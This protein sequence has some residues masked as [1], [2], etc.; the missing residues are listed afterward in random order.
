MSRPPRTAPDRAIAGAG[1]DPIDSLPSLSAPRR[2]DA[3]LSR[4]GDRVGPVLS[5]RAASPV[6]W[7]RDADRG[8]SESAA[9][10]LRPGL[11]GP[12]V[13]RW[14]RRVRDPAGWIESDLRRRTGRSDP[15]LREPQ[16]RDD[17]PRLPR[18]PLARRRGRRAGSA[19]S[20]LRSGLRDQSP[21][22]R[23]LHRDDRLRRARR[24]RLQQDRALPDPRERSGAGRSGDAH[25]DPR[26]PPALCEPQRR[27]RRVRS[28]RNA[29]RRDGRW[30]RGNRSR[31]QFA[32]PGL[33]A[34]KAAAPRRAPGRAFDRTRRQSIRRDARRRP[35]RVPLRPA[36]SLAHQL[37]SRHRRS[38]HRRRRRRTSRGS[39]PHSSRNARRAQLRLGLL[40]G[41][42]QFPER[43][44]LLRH[45]LDAALP[46]IRPQRSRRRRPRDR[47]LRLSR[48]RLPR[49]LRRLSLLRC[50]V[51]PALG[52]GRTGSGG[53][54]ESREPG[55][56]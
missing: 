1:L 51:A 28:R 31:E 4:P 47:R 9:D 38:L 29:L 6:R 42:A 17:L 33:A 50:P 46:R 41:D 22:L 2:R 53:S 56:C 10:D 24:G 35:A 8:R 45:F 55:A 18:H 12:D 49:A 27:P 21:V 25:G 52:L 32:E 11:H 16:R 5:A 26:V 19:R 43:R 48:R 40:R 15:R 14:A 44:A 3:D 36:Q 23:E 30:R 13:A 20:G 37:R 54:L 34:R 7:P 39:E